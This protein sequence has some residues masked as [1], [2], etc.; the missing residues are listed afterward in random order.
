MSGITWVMVER[1]SS[2]NDHPGGI[3]GGEGGGLVGGDGRLDEELNN[4][5]ASRVVFGG[6]LGRHCCQTSQRRLAV[7]SGVRT[8]SK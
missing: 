2:N 6:G 7:S 1:K 5:W 4:F 8:G 3:I